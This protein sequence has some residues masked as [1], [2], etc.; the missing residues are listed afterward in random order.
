M[1]SVT[2]NSSPYAFLFNVNKRILAFLKIYKNIFLLSSLR[3][4][5]QPTDRSPTETPE[6]ATLIDTLKN[7]LSANDPAGP[8]TREQ[9]KET[10][11]KLSLALETAPET[12]QRIA[13][14]VSSTCPN[15]SHKKSDRPP[16]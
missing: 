14:Y 11:E 10:A 15:E 9:L 4:T 6:V 3:D 12:V 1:L 13:Y 16:A 7:V 5:M 2:L 8:A